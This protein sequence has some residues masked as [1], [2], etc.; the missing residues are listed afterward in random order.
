MKCP[1][2]S[3]NEFR[4]TN[5]RDFSEEIR[6]RRECLKCGKRF[7]TYERIAKIEFYVIKK[8]FSNN[9]LVVTNNPKHK[10]LFAKQALIN[11]ISLISLSELPKKCECRIRYREKLTKCG[12]KKIEHG[13][14]AVKFKDLQWAVSPGQSI[15]F[16]DKDVC[17]GGGI[18]N[19]SHGMSRLDVA[20]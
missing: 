11:K 12:I 16:Y 20:K 4:V 1:Y 6:R 2:C 9:E 3:S 19:G 7:T 13:K 15:V 5:K 8:D 14:Y 10:A 18:I 17:L